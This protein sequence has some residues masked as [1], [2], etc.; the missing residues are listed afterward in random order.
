MYIHVY[1]YVCVCMYVY[2]YIYM[3]DLARDALKLVRRMWPH[4][5]ARGMRARAR[6]GPCWV[7]IDGFWFRPGCR[8]W[9]PPLWGP[10]PDKSRFCGPGD[11]LPGR[12]R[13][14]RVLLHDG[15][16]PVGSEHRPVWRSGKKKCVYKY[17]CIYV[18]IYVYIY[19][20]IYIYIHTYIHTYIHIYVPTRGLACSLAPAR[21]YANM[22]CV[23]ML[24]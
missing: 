1:V 24:V 20:Y 7:T 19:I 2:T 15:I 3:F 8:N 17:T 13:R 12:P 4:R 11:R 21:P 14:W 5:S 23:M 16:C 6:N 18:C 10:G 9:S 22:W